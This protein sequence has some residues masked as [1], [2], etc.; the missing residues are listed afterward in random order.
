M[1]AKLPDQH[2]KALDKR[3]GPITLEPRNFKFID[4][5]VADSRDIGLNH[6]AGLSLP[7]QVMMTMFSLYELMDEKKDYQK[8]CMEIVHKRA[9]AMIDGRGLHLD[10][11]PNVE[12]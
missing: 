2:L 5:I 9:R 11:H 7:Q 1:I 12:D 4:R 6:T 3:Y 10:P 8:A